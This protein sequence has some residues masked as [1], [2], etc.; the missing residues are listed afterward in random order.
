[1][2]AIVLD[3]DTIE[4]RPAVAGDFWRAARRHGVLTRSLSYGAAV[5]PP[6]IIDD[7]EQDMIVSCLGA[8][9]D[10]VHRRRR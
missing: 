8:A 3:G 5:A 9:L 7:A 1:M 10:E 6:L 2:A 4:E